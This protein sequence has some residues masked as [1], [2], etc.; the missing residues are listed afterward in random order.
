MTWLRGKKTKGI[1]GKLIAGVFF[2]FFIVL[3]S[4]CREGS[5]ADDGHHTD[6]TLQGDTVLLSPSST[7]Q[8]QFVHDTVSDQLFQLE[9]TTAG[10]V[11]AIPNNYA[12]IAPPFAGRVLKSYVRLGQKVNPGAPIFEMSSPAFFMA[13]KEYFDAKQA[14]RQGELNLKRQKDLLRNGVGIARELEEAE[15]TFETQKTALSNA[16]AALR[17]FNVDLAQVKLGQALVVT[18]PIRGEVVTNNIVIGQYLREEAEPLAVVAELSKVWIVG[19]VKEKDVPFIN[20]LDAVNVKMAAFPDRLMRGK[21][22]HIN[23]IVNE[24][25]RS[26]EVLVECDNYQQDLRPGMYVTV[27]FKDAPETTILVPTEALFQEEKGQFVFMKLD[28]RRYEKRR[29]ETRGTVNGKVIV[30]TGLKVGEVI[31][32]SGGSLMLLR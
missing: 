30:S 13:Q 12:E 1:S 6:Y 23:K 28:A 21:I 8:H 18:A 7:L 5:S 24:E 32:S 14:F 2:V 10:I 3:F 9:L 19:Q 27:L 25:T 29:V 4:A 20:E 16:G 15:T 26:V 11:R 22:K 17:I 31:V